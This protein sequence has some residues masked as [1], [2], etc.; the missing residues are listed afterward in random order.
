MTCRRINPAPGCASVLA[1]SKPGTAEALTP[2]RTVLKALTQ[3]NVESI[4][5][6]IDEIT[7]T[8]IRTK[9]GRFEEFDLIACATCVD[10]TAPGDDLLTFFPC[11]TVASRTP[12]FLDSK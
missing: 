10:A 8:G 6:D 9:D 3:P 7:E 5:S 12:G 11:R 1:G 4:W 2:R